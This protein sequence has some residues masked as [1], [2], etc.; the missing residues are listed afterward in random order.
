MIKIDGLTSKERH[1][2]VAERSQGLCELCYS[3]NMVQH[4]HI[5]G[6]KGRRTQ[7]ETVYSLIA[8]C[9]ECHHGTNGIHGKNGYELDLK[10]KENLHKTYEEMGLSGEE[11]KYWLGGR[12]YLQ[13]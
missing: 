13:G 9:W 5:I 12:F 4:H 1:K 7:C 10:L 2:K 3:P 11:L 8:L 6:G